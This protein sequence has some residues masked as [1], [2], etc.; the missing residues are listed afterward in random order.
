MTGL[1]HRYYLLGQSHVEEAQAIT[2]LPQSS[3]VARRIHKNM[4]AGLF[5][6]YL[7]RQDSGLMG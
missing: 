6:T 7:S 4:G 1:I 2:S 3:Q 5:I